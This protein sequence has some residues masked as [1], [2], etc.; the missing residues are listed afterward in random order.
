M[1]FDLSGRT[2]LVTGAGQN[3]GAGIARMLAAQ[4]AV[5]AVNDIA[6]ERANDTVQQIIDA[7]GKAVAAPFDVTSYDILVPVGTPSPLTISATLSGFVGVGGSLSNTTSTA[8]VITT[9][10]VGFNLTYKGVAEVGGATGAA[11]TDVFEGLTWKFR[12][13]DK[14]GKN[15]DLTCKKP[16]V[17]WI[18]KRALGKGAPTVP[19]VQFCP[20]A[21]ACRLAVAGSSRPPPMQAK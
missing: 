8:D 3:V 5:V 21:E 1:L 19:H 15:V 9:N 7:G 2:A 17:Q 14:D 4:G 12:G 10:A 6:P 18:R 16:F 13:K 20:L 11:F